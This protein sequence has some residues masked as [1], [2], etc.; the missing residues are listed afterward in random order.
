ML[1]AL[2]I[3]GVV[4]TALST[5]ATLV[6]EFK[7]AY[8]IGATPRK[9]Q[10]SNI[11][12]AAL[13]AIVVSL[14]IILLDKVYGFAPGPG[15]PNPLPAPQPNAMAAVIKSLMTSAETPWFLY[16][17]GGVIAVIVEVL[18]IS[19]LAFAL[20]MY[21][22]IELN[23]PILAG[24]IVAWFVKRN[25]HSGDTGEEQDRG[26]L[27]ASGLIAGGALIGVIGS[28]IRWIESQSGKTLLPDVGNTGNAGNWLALAMFA[29]LCIAIYL[30]VRKR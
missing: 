25:R 1:A 16:A 18:G 2:L 19:S 17:T 29:I 8:W 12:G 28:F 15:H 24:A 27:I 9:V 4:C 14:V 13:A 5:T 30:T 23:S 21:I 22:P 11:L 10:I 26:T 3:G 20:G 6:T 7:V